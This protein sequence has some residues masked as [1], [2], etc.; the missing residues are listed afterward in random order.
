MGV[1]AARESVPVCAHAPPARLKCTTLC[2]AGEAVSAT[3]SDELDSNTKVQ[4]SM[5]EP[6]KPGSSAV[7]GDASPVGRPAPMVNTPAHPSSA[8]ESVPYSC[9][10]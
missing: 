8:A 3:H 2:V 10:P 9:P 5:P 4:G 1:E 7:E 6:V